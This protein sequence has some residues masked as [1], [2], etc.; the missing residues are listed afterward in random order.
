MSSTEVTF[1]Q[2]EDCCG[3][4]CTDGKWKMAKKG[5]ANLRGSAVGKSSEDA[6]YW[7]RFGPTSSLRTHL[8]LV[9][10]FDFWGRWST[11]M[12]EMEGRF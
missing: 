12:Y 9:Y 7:I 1:K 5:S 2:G 8:H 10:S 4:N 6:I 3:C 11:Y